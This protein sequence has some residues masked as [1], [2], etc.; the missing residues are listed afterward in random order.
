[1][2]TTSLKVAIVSPSLPIRSGLMKSQPISLLEVTSMA[3]PLSVSKDSFGPHVYCHVHEAIRFLKGGE[4]TEIV[5][6]RIVDSEVV[7]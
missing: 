1:M 3:R 4:I 6:K 2:R 7:A 5:K